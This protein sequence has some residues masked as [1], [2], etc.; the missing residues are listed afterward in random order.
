MTEILEKSNK[1]YNKKDIKKI[2]TETVLSKLQDPD[3][4]LDNNYTHETRK[5]KLTSVFHWAMERKPILA[6]NGTFYKTHEEARNP[7]SE[8]VDG[9]LDDRA[10][11]KAKL[12]TRNASKVVSVV[13]ITDWAESV[14][15]G[16]DHFE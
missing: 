16:P 12:S 1:N 15:A 10:A 2:V 7:I 5:S 4:V 11:L 8:M 3:V 9:F 14:V 13:D 6:G